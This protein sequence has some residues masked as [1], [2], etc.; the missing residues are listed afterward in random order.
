[1]DTIQLSGVNSVLEGKVWRVDVGD[2]IHFEHRNRSCLE[3][4]MYRTKIA[5]EVLKCEDGSEKV[6]VVEQKH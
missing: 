3:D 4:Y 1:M 5:L 2:N 6:S